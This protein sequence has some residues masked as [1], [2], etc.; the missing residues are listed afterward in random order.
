[1]KQHSLLLLL[2]RVGVWY[3]MRKK[4]T[5]VY[6]VYGSGNDWK[7][8]RKKKKKKV[9]IGRGIWCCYFFFFLNR[10]ILNEGPFKAIWSRKAPLRWRGWLVFFSFSFFFFSLISCVFSLYLSTYPASNGRASSQARRERDHLHFCCY[11]LLV[12]LFASSFLF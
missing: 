1:M 2:V 9:S 3:K 8:R 10:F 5:Y 7:L 4:S 11:S 6:I 12:L